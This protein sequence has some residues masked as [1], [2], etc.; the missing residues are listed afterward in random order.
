MVGMLRIITTGLEAISEAVSRKSRVW[1]T[2]TLVTTRTT[3]N[4]WS[5]GPSKRKPARLTKGAHEEDK[6]V[7]AGVKKAM[8]RVES[9]EHKT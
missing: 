6:V 3:Q 4:T 5:R 8:A 7:R 1:C 2:A 9:G